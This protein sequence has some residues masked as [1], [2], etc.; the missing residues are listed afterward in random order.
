MKPGLSGL[1]Q[2]GMRDRV[3][4]YAIQDDDR[5]VRHFPQQPI[6]Q[7]RDGKPHQRHRAPR[8]QQ[9]G[10]EC[11]ARQ[12]LGDLAQIHDQQHQ[13]RRLHQRQ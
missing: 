4:L 10:H 3:D 7:P 9:T 12:L 2:Q 6:A 8:K 1:D 13:H 11:Q 5:Q